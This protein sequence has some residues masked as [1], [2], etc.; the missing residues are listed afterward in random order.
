VIALHGD[1][2]EIAALHLFEA[3]PGVGRDGFPEGC[4][5]PPLCRVFSHGDRLALPAHL[6]GEARRAG[7]GHPDLNRAQPGSPEL[8]RR[9]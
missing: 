3:I 6:L 8:I 1:H 2:D 9:C 5:R 4:L 7:V